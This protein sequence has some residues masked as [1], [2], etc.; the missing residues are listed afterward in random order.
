L[1]ALVTGGAGFI[2][3]WV[4][5]ELLT[6]GHEVTVLDNLS[7][8]RRENLA[9]FLESAGFNGLVEGDIRERELLARAF[10]GQNV[11]YHLAASINVQNSIDDPGETFDN[12]VAGTFNVLEECRK[13]NTRMIFVSTCMVYERA[14]PDG[15]ID[16]Q[17]PVRPTSPYAAAKLA[18]EA[19]TLSYHHAYRLPAVVLRPFNTYGPYQ[20]TGGEGGVVAVFTD[21][22]LKGEKLTVY[23]DGTQTRDFLYA[24]DCARF[25]VAAGSRYGLSGEIV[26][27]GS[28]R[29]I[30]INEL[31][32][33]ICPEK[34]RIIHVPHIHPRSEIEKLV[35]D[36]RK[37]ERLLGWKP[38]V[39]LEDGLTRTRNWMEMG[40][41]GR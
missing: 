4:V 22:N 1:R 36:W 19:L 33:L 13:N 11:C 27:A 32:C 34:E 3:R 14:R 30:T 26:N 6:G 8:G 7:A 2:G 40:V 15:G 18:G 17:H 35:C 39:S 31:T 10:P 29:D 23:G 37:A 28:G 9:Q 38:L 5:K 24:E 21:R 20:R 41:T 12:D 25:I 16:E